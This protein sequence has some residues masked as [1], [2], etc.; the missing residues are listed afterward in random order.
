MRFLHHP[1]DLIRN[2]HQMMF[3]TSAFAIGAGVVAVAAAGTAA[4]VSMSA[5]SRASKA[6]GAAAGKYKKQQGQAVSE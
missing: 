2:K 5:A 1:E 6:Q 3:H 4:A